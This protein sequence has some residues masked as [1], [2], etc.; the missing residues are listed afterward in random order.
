L[1]IT[2]ADTGQGI[3]AE[4]LPQVFDRFRQG[5]SSTTRNYGG[6]GLGLAIVRHL[7]ELHGGT[8]HAESLGEG[9]GATFS[10]VFPLLAERAQPED[11]GQNGSRRIKSSTALNGLRVLVVDD[12]ADAR[13]IISTV[14]ERTGAEVKA[15]ESASEALRLL[16]QWHPDVLMSD[17][18][19]PGEDGYSFINK[20]R[21]LPVDQ[22]GHTPA[23]AFTAYAREEDRKRALDAG[24]QMHIAKPVTSSKLVAMLADLAGRVSSVPH[25]VADD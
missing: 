17:I 3:S 8:V 10:A 19:M 2:V 12:E 23:A 14:I 20:V 11:G 22:G 25:A 6:L 9:L 7:V 15:C 16:Q 24:F 1:R 4:F 21:S 13:Q 5:D 18:A